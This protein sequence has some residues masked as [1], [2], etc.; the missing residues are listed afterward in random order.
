MARSEADRKRLAALKAKADA[1]AYRDCILDS[2]AVAYVRGLASVAI[3]E[4]FG[5]HLRP[6]ADR[7]ALRNFAM[8]DYKRRYPRA[9]GVRLWVWRADRQGSRNGS[10]V[11]RFCGEYLRNNVPMGRGGRYTEALWDHVQRCALESLAGLR[12]PVAPG[13]APAPARPEVAFTHDLPE[14]VDQI[15]RPDLPAESFILELDPC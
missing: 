15:G 9:M 11:C 10:Q 1:K 8:L 5:A 13:A 3:D 6:P 7:L 2:E 14:G 4:L 12:E